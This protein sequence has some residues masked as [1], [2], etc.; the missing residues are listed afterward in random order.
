M[1]AP[2][3]R[4]LLLIALAG[5]V[6]ALVYAVR[7]ILPPFAIALALTYLLDPLIRQL[8]RR[9]LSRLG[10]LVAVYS[11]LTL[12][13]VAIVHFLVPSFVIQVNRLADD[14]PHYML[15]VQEWA[16]ELQAGYTRTPLPDAV[17]QVVDQAVNDLE[18]TLLRVVERLVGGL[19]ALL[20]G[21]FSLVL[22]PILAFYLLRDLDR[23]KVSVLGF[24]P[25]GTRG[26]ILCLLREIDS[27]VGGFVRGQLLVAVIT[28]FLSM[29]AL[30][31]L[32]V[33]FSILLGLFIAVTDIIPYVGP[34]LGAIPALALALLDSP[35]KALQVV[36]ALAAVQQL[37]AVVVQPR[38]VGRT[39]GLHPILVIFAVL[40]GARLRGAIG[41]LLAVPVVA[42]AGVL[43]RYL[44][45]RAAGGPAP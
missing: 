25:A 7:A 31:L 3:P 4:Q 20:G 41:L 17:R 28:G 21:M 18:A 8:V 14:I 33:N 23:L 26:E 15:Q 27:C 19:A 37:E 9:G 5:V 35:L 34:V 11:A 10:A 13:A 45:R 16:A 2:T 42:V 1:R 32:G 44:Y 40:A 36:A 29:V 6:F 24:I 43:W 22:A 38:V 39:V 12:I 30:A